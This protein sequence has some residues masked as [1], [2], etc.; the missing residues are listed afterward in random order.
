ML[1]PGGL[2]ELPLPEDDATAL[3]LICAI[4]D[5]QTIDVPQTLDAGDTLR[6]AVTVNKY[7]CLNALNLPAE[8]SF[9]LTKTKLPI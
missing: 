3:K 9:D 6:V 7:D 5:S 8:I 2:I 4:I 1:D